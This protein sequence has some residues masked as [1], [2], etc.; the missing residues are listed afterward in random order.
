MSTLKQ[1]F[2]ELEAEKPEIT[3][4]DLARATGAKPPSV[5]AWFT[6]DSKSMKSATAVKAAALYGVSPLWLATGEGYK[7]AQQ[8]HTEHAQVATNNAAPTTAGGQLQA[9]FDMIP[10]GPLREPAYNACF[11]ILMTAIRQSANPPTG[12]TIQVQSPEKQRV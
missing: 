12:D 5:N 1:R 8:P 7:K 6:G 4:A 3:Q 2:A 10:A 11:T 9:L